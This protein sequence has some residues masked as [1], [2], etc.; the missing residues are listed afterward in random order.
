MEMIVLG[1]VFA[2][3]ITLLNT[4]IDRLEKQITRFEDLVNQ[5]LDEKQDK[6]VM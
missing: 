1:I 6:E 3:V 4:K 5:A 2:V